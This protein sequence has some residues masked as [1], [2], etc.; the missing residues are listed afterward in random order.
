LAQEPYTQAFTIAEEA[1]LSPEERWFYEGSLKQARTSY[2]ELAAAEQEGERKKA[3]QIAQA[4]LAQGF[5]I[6]LIT[7]MTGLS[8]TEVSGLRA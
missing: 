7:Q 3:F 1:A 8:E 5:A 6:P 4:M 2:A